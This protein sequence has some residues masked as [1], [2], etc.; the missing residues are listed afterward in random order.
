MRFG[1]DPIATDICETT[2]QSKRESV[3]SLV[4]AALL[5]RLDGDTRSGGPTLP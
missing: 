1:F 5:N 4:V 3:V 2:G